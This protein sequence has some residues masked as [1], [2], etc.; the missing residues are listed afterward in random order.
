MSDIPVHVPQL[1]GDA[2]ALD[3]NPTYAA[4]RLA[5]PVAWAELS[6]GVRGL[7]VTSH[8]AAVELLSSPAGVYTR[9]TRNWTALAEGRVPPDSPLL[10]ILGW[11]PSLLYADGAEHARLRTVIEDCMSRV[12]SWRLKEITR[13]VA[14]GIITE[15]RANGRAD[16][17]TEYAMAVP[18]LVFTELLDCPPETSRGMVEACAKII[19]AT[20]DAAEAAEAFGGMLAGLVALKRERPGDDLTSW[21]ISHS[22]ELSFE[23][24]VSSLYT[25]IGAGHVPTST[26]IV[27]ALKL[28]LTNDDYS[29]DLTAGAV[30]VRRAME[31]ALWEASPLSTFTFHF[32]ISDTRLHG[33]FIPKGVPVMISHHATNTDPSLPS[34]ISYDSRAHLAFSAGEHRCPVPV[35]AAII[36][37]EAITAVLEHLWDVRLTD[38]GRIPNR[39]GLFHQ[40]PAHLNVAFTPAAAATPTR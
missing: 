9:D 10:G 30:S 24:V 25:L 11:R 26:W 6:P 27:Q 32:A 34:T 15:L 31:K 36:T 12:R 20:P 35:H 37:Q 16:L 23:E 39:P 3:P 7:V 19:D 8:P 18:L 13:E 14:L 29:G 22:A 33:V 17:L 38:R 28:L 21:M 1:F 5:G 4:L 40:C 2:F